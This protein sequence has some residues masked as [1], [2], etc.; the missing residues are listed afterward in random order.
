MAVFRDMF[1]SLL[2]HKI[3]RGCQRRCAIQDQHGLCSLCQAN[4]HHFVSMRR[5]LRALPLLFQATQS[6]QPAHLRL[7]GRS[8]E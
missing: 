2:F 4:V 6:R 3:C 1:G 8:P 5:H 7:I